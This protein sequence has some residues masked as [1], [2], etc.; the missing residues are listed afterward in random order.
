MSSN[1]TNST[2]SDL[3]E[4]MIKIGF[5]LC[6]Q[7]NSDNYNPIVISIGFSQTR[8]DLEKELEILKKNYS[9]R[10]ERFN[11]QSDNCDEYIEKFE[12]AWNKFEQ[13]NVIPYYTS[14]ITQSI[15]KPQTK[16]EH[17]EY[18][19]IKDFNT[20]NGENNRALNHDEK[21]KFLSAWMNLNLPAES[22]R[23]FIEVSED[24]SEILSSNYKDDISYFICEI[25]KEVKEDF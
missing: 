3:K 2:E 23:E 1:L 16:E 4:S 17:A 10:L 21:C 8:S 13:K 18:K 5:L 15:I 11:S 7:D 22:F 14:G 12:K 19:R 9:D 6:S 25:G 24:G 20:R